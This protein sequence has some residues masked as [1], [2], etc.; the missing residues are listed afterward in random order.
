MPFDRL[1]WTAVLTIAVGLVVITLWTGWQSRERVIEAAKAATRNA[2][3]ILNQHAART[4]G[5]VDLVL[6]VAANRS[7]AQLRDGDAGETLQLLADLLKDV[8]YLQGVQVYD[9]GTGAAQVTTSRAPDALA[10]A[11]RA[12]VERHRQSDSHELR[13]GDPVWN[14]AGRHWMLTMSRRLSGEGHPNRF[15]AVA[16]VKLGEIQAFYDSIATG[17][18]DSIVL[19]RSD[20]VLLAQHPLNP[21]D[22]GRDLSA[23]PL[24]T[25]HLPS[26]PPGTY[27]TVSEARGATHI[28]SYARLPGLPLVMV[29]TLNQ[30]EALAEWRRNALR[31]L[32]LSALTILLVLGLGGLVGREV[33]R[34]DAAE[35]ELKRQTALVQATLE[36]MDQGLLMFDA[37]ERIRV[38]NRRVADLLDIPAHVFAG[39]TFRD[40]RQYQLDNDEFANSDPKF[41]TWVSEGG[42]AGMRHTYERVRPNGTV[43]E[44]RTVPLADGGAVR[45]FTDITSRKTA[46]IALEEAKGLAEAARSHAE[47]VSQA[48]SEFLAS[49]S[50]EIR[51]PLNSILGFTDLLLHSGDLPPDKQRYSE[52][53]RSAGLALLTVVDDILDFSKIEAGRVELEPAPFRLA[54]LIDNSVS[55]IKGTAA[56][57]KLAVDVT[58]DRDLPDW[59][60]ADEARLRQVILNLLNNA[61]KF[62][63]RGSV[64][65]T[66]GQD[67]PEGPRR[68]L[69]FSVTDT[70]IGIPKDKQGRLFQR[71]SQV[72][73]SIRREFGGTGLGL[74]ICKRLVEL[75]GGQIGVTSEPGVG[76]TFWFTVACETTEAPA[77]E[78]AGPAAYGFDALRT[79]RILLVEDIEANQEIA[80]AVLEGAGHSV[81]VAGD[82]F[83]A[84]RA[85]R[86][87]EYDLV[88]MD[89]QMPGMDGLTATRRIRELPGPVRNIPII[90][91]TAN[92]LPEQVAE[93][94]ACGMNDHIGKPF[95]RKDLYAMIDRWLPEFMVVETVPAAS[96][97]PAATATLDREV[98]E[99]LAGLLGPE[100]LSDHLAKLEARL[101]ASL[102]TAAAADMPALAQQAHSLISQAGM[103]GF[104]TLSDVCR[105]LETACI[106]GAAI[107]DLLARARAA[108]DAALQEIGA[109]R[110]S[111]AQSAA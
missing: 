35:A 13:I 4:I 33:R 26:A 15:I 90:A 18:D 43:L 31:N 98:Y 57:K 47:R 84:L 92:V 17:P 74:A 51:T 7:S 71:F 111:A 89:V 94:R 9:A 27:Q 10:P 108:R 97:A 20:G 14:E 1:V 88:L 103:L 32:A 102:Q 56:G 96:L 62:T 53:I 61:V 73:G 110:G 39:A 67:T 5:S 82:G 69:R 78:A 64:T 45:T 38:H 95:Q 99:D 91:M 79:G 28:V 101:L 40:I 41:K 93:F 23:S 68:R 54:A 30:D 24:F 70:G 48:K 46:E 11:V 83:E 104:T 77:V 87:R 81:E 85:L 66:V 42:V 52:R 59:I 100:K 2:A 107:T 44:I 16:L 75:M 50:H 34:R 72:D 37:D 19:Y 109:L 60:L 86:T 55:I 12:A 22:L 29:A 58:L 3:E 80:R 76:S 21:A 36:N 106:E 6:R 8:P 49:M 105:D 65:L 25:E 63:P